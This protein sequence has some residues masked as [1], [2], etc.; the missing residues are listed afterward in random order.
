MDE[1]MSNIEPYSWDYKDPKNGQGR[2]TGVMAQDLQKS[3]IGRQMVNQAQDGTLM[4]D[5]KR[6]AATAIAASALTYKENQQLK[7]LINNLNTKF[8]K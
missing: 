7:K 2:Y 4:V 6:M 1:L 5:V 3:E 8:K